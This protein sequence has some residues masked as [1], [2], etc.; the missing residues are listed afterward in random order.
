MIYP[1]QQQQW[2]SI[3]NMISQQRL[4]QSLLLQGTAG[5]GKFDFAKCI[6][7]TLLCEKPQQFACDHCRACQLRKAQSH[8][9]LFIVTP[10]EKSKAIRI[11]QIRE[12]SE[13][14][15][16]TPQL[17]QCQVAIISPADA[18]NRAAANALLKT[19]EEPNGR[20]L[21]IL[22]ASQLSHLPATILSRC[23]RLQFSAAE[24][25]ATCAWLQNQLGSSVDASLL[26]RLA[27]HAPLKAIALAESNYVQMRDQLLQHLWK[28]SR[29]SA[30]PLSSVT[31]YVKHDLQLFLY[32]LLTLSMDVA[33]LQL[34]VHTNALVNHD[35]TEPLQALGKC[36]RATFLQ[37]YIEKIQHAYR[38]SL[39]G[40]H[41][42]PQLLLES[43]LID[44]ACQ[45][46]I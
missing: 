43:L 13:K 37:S 40:T 25:E 44:W 28:L 31:E 21:L 20:V 26:L 15:N 38:L 5:M 34:G 29:E 1:W 35:R 33:K 27:D 22:V 9:D 11:D 45:Q 8:P 46:S 23:Q 6:A 24:N 19:L 4:A 7:A 3:Q 42:N 30:N 36:L 41:L 14:L 10:L 17:G 16:H 18:L 32:A 12:L 39:S 2:L